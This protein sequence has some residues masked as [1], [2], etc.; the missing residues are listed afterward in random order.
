MKTTISITVTQSGTPA[1]GA[2]L[3]VL[4]TLERMAFLDAGCEETEKEITV[5][6][7]GISGTATISRRAQ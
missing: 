6:V 5:A 3:A 7:I 2:E 4:G 1:P